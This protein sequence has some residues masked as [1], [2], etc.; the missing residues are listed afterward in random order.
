MSNQNQGKPWPC[1]E[2]GENLGF[3]LYGQLAVENI[4]ANSDGAN[5]VIKCPRCAARKVWY[6]KD[7]MSHMLD[8]LASEVA[9]RIQKDSQRNNR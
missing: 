1:P 2:C 9:A 6:A 3:I 8:Y 5:W 4:T 7:S